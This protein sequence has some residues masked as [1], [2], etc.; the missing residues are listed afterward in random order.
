MNDYRPSGFSILPPVVK[1]LI[2]INGLLFLATMVLPIDLIDIL[3]LHYFASEKFRV[4]QLITYMFMHG[5]M[6][7]IFFNMFAVWMFGNAIENLWGPRR[8]LA[9]YL[10]TGLGAAFIHYLVVHFQM[11]PIL[12]VIN[13]YLANPDPDKLTAFLDSGYFKIASSEIMQN[14]NV[15]RSEYNFLLQT[16]NIEKAMNLSVEF[17]AQYKTDY[18]NAHVVVG[19]SGSLFGI[20]LAFGMMFPNQQIFLLFFPFPIKAKYFVMIYG[21]IELISGLRGS[22]ED[23]VAHFAHLG[24]MLF[25]FLLIKIWQTRRTGDY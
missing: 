15:F 18:L 19:A 10:I 6:A 7:H 25:G 17:L 14:Y 20:L 13:D 8:F 5:G 22:P 21:A 24:G 3:G 1:N 4:Y 11:L 2:I 23:N 9:Y 16:G 12:A